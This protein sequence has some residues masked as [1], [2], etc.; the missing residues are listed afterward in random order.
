MVDSDDEQF[1]D[2]DHFT[3]KEKMLLEKHR[4]RINKKS[5]RMEESVL[6]FDDSSDEDEELNE[7]DE[8]GEDME[9]D[10]VLDDSEDDLPNLQNWGKKKKA[11]Y[12]TDFVD[13]DFGTLNEREE[14]AAKLEE[15]EALRIQKALVEQLDEDDFLLGFDEKPAEKQQQD[16][17]Q[18]KEVK[19][20]LSSMSNREKLEIFRQ[21]NP[22][23]SSLV[24]EFKGNVDILKNS[25]EPIR[26][27]LTKIDISVAEDGV[28]LSN[29]LET[30]YQV[31]SNY[32]INLSF[33]L[34]LK[35]RRV[36]VKSHPVAR[37]LLQ[38]RILLRKIHK[39][40]IVS[41]E[42]NL[43]QRILTLAEEQMQKSVPL[44]EMSNK[45]KL[46]VEK[47]L[48]TIDL[49]KDESSEEE[50][51]ESEDEEMAA[52]DKDQKSDAEEEGAEE[53]MD[54]EGKRKITYQIAKNKGLTPYRK[55][56]LRNPRVKHRMK[57]RKAVIRRKGQI[58]EHR[59]EISKYG[60][61]LSGIK[62]SVTKSVKFK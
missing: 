48:D 26:E 42:N 38:Y 62:A 15:E 36:S 41:K 9:S 27:M 40:W 25:V 43:I 3:D 52:K 35:A 1:S 56:E 19:R 57:Y 20:D 59:P 50:Q 24:E 17:L 14:E 51:Q 54:E 18:Q 5:S 39:K 49:T 10:D 55:K 60:G 45:H 23:F 16:D 46:F 13:K 32:N 6:G 11:Y 53:D 30:Y 31:L 44:K 61:E 22:E 12:D 7:G 21:E 28:N 33:Y 34:L 4:S 29:A 47:L 8:D 58:R 2:N 37:R